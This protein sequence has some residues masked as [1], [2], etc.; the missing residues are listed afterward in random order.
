M[1][2]FPDYIL[3]SSWFVLS[4]Q[5]EYMGTVDE[6][7][8]KEKYFIFDMGLLLLLDLLNIGIYV[9]FCISIYQYQYSILILDYILY[10]I[11]DCKYWII[12]WVN[13]I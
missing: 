7:F 11:L 3:Y 6:D 8:A 4:A 1:H 12:H 10:C 13:C 2:T 9:L 5:Y